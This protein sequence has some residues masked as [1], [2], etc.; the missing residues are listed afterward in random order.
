MSAADDAGAVD[1][2]A[3]VVRQLCTVNFRCG[4]S[5]CGVKKSL[6]DNVQFFCPGDEL[7]DV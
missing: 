7:T 5:I 1:A 2:R 3:S 4:W 6:P